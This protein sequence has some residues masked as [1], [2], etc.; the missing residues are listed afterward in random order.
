LNKE[1]TMISETDE[2][3]H[4]IEHTGLDEAQRR[5]LRRLARRLT[6]EE[7]D[8]LLALLAVVAGHAE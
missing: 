3:V 8:A 4:V 1:S 2:L 7:A 6:T 5:L